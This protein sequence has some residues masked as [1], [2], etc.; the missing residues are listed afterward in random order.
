MPKI[1]KSNHRRPNRKTLILAAAAL[2]VFTAVALVERAQKKRHASAAVTLTQ[3]AAEPPRPWIISLLPS[4]TE[5][6]YMLGLGDHL[7]AR[8]QYCDFPPVVTNLPIVGSLGAANIEAIARLKPDYVL[9]PQLDSQS[10]AHEA[11][12]K[13]RIN[14]IGI[15]ANSFDDIVQSIWDLAKR[16]DA[17]ENATLWLEH[18]N[19]LTAQIK[20]KPPRR[21]PRV[22]FCAGRDAGSFDRIYISGAGNFY[23]D[24]VNRCGG[25]NAYTGKLSTPMLSAEGVIKANPDIIIDVLINANTIDIAEALEQ[26]SRLATVNAIRTGDV[27]ILNDP[28]AARPGP[29][30]DTLMQTIAAFIHEWDEKQ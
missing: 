12:A 11:L 1:A 29:R 7:I 19:D 30:I 9:L 10:K 5:T 20:A 25:A 24:V 28:W 2:L 21:T 23:E 26:W 18:I 15:P 4:V 22:L 14:H 13:L 16:F 27:H 3:S 6:I 8:S 17:E